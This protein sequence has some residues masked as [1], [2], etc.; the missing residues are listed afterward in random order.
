VNR[1]QQ[2]GWQSCRHHG[3]PA[4]GWT[5]REPSLTDSVLTG[6]GVRAEATGRADIRARPTLILLQGERRLA[7]EVS[8]ASDL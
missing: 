5:L 2:K 8:L 1:Q 4:G 6:F 7:S 3:S